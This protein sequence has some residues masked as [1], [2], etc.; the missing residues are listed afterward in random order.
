MFDITNDIDA[1]FNEFD[2]GVIATLNN[3]NTD[4]ITLLYFNN[5]KSVTS[6]NSSWGVQGNTPL[7]YIKESDVV[8]YNINQDDEILINNILYRI[9]ELK[10]NDFIF[11][12]ILELV[13]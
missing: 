2:F 4:K 12:A 6:F 13:N 5:Y 8:N 1:M 11:E 7:C 10:N 3:D 9:V